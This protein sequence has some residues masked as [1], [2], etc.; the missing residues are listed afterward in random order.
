MEWLDQYWFEM[1]PIR[2]HDLPEYVPDVAAGSSSPIQ[3]TKW[4]I[5]A[6]KI[7]ITLERRGYVTRLDFK[8]QGIDHRRWL[9]VGTNWLRAV[10]GKFVAWARDSRIS[11]SSIPVSMRR[12]RRPPRNG[13][14]PLV[15]R[16]LAD[17]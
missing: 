12:S 16:R 4:K 8:K 3:L 14:C 2:R 10:D 7:A 9:A 13:C 5:A 6:I 17:R 15:R 11:G 1:A